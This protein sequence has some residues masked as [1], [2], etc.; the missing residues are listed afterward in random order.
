MPVEAEW[1]K[2]T[3]NQFDIVAMSYENYRLLKLNTTL[4]IPA[5]YKVVIVDDELDYICRNTVIVKSI[6]DV[7][8]LVEKK[9]RLLVICDNK[10][11]KVEDL[12]PIS[13]FIII[14]HDTMNSHPSGIKFTPTGHNCIEVSHMEDENGEYFV[15]KIL[16][17]FE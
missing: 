13:Y 9:H 14:V 12:S 6:F 5:F 10:K 4:Y 8:G 3:L 11:I 17:Q 1:I 16:K 15:T 2:K 7:P